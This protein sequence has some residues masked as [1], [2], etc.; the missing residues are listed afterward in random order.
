MLKSDGAPVITACVTLHC[1]K[2]FKLVEIT[3]T[4]LLVSSSFTA[5]LSFVAAQ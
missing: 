3:P 4:I 1:W 2:G 5:P